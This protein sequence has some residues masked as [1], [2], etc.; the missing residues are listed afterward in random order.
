MINFIPIDKG[1]NCQLIFWP[2]KDA[3]SVSLYPFNRSQRLEYVKYTKWIKIERNVNILRQI[4]CFGQKVKTQQQIK[5]SN[6]K[7]L[8][9]PGFEFGTSRTQCGCVTSAPPSQLKVSIVVVKLFNHFDAMGRCVNKQSRICGPRICNKVLFS[10]KIVIFMDIYIWQ[11]PMFTG[12]AFT[13]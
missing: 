4:M 13:A 6:I 7:P 3:R 12:L 8:P 9:E 11:V 2:I 5:K 1:Y 10:V